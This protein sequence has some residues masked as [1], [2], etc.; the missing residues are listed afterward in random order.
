MDRPTMAEDTIDMIEKSFGVHPGYR[1]AHSRGELYEAEFTPTGK[2]ADWTTAP[3]FTGGTV[4]AAVRFSHFSPNPYWADDAS[5][6]KGMAVRFE[7]PDGSHASI[8]SV[9]APV[10]FAKTPGTFNEMVEIYRSFRNG[11]PHFGQ[12]M[13]L[14][15]R[16]PD[17]RAWLK[18]FRKMKAPASF[19]TSPYYAIHA[20]Y[21]IDRHGRRQP[22]KYEWEPNAGKDMLPHGGGEFG[23]FERELDRRLSQGPIGFRL[24]I[25]IGGQGD[26][27]D[28]PTKMWPK[29]RER[30]EIGQLIVKRRIGEPDPILFD[31]SEVTAGIEPSEDPILQ[32]RS[33]AYAVSY[34]RRVEER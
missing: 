9:T 31:P 11:R 1:R 29:D 6:V 15:F 5:P 23:Y 21:F 33:P 20:F 12:L 28:D 18:V 7:L 10:F 2:A 13:K 30:I 14:F 19:A 25:T 26:P 27:T 22:V 34:K 17:S 4:R 24:F 16:Y 8:V 32:Y 3:H